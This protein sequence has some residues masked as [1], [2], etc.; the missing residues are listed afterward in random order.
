[1]HHKIP[2]AGLI[3]YAVQ[4]HR[5]ISG[6]SAICGQTCCRDQRQ[7]DDFCRTLFCPE[8]VLFC[9]QQRLCHGPA[10]VRQLYCQLQVR[11]AQ[12][13]QPAGILQT[14]AGGAQVW[15]VDRGFPASLQHP[16]Y[17]PRQHGSWPFFIKGSQHNQH[18]PLQWRRS[19]ALGHY[20][21]SSGQMR[22]LRR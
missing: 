10:G 5:Q 14:T 12:G 20:L 22:F 1:M 13:T 4:L 16:F 15:P 21:S 17:V 6:R 7:Y 3:R 19:A 9:Q 8:A 2:T 11:S 18:S